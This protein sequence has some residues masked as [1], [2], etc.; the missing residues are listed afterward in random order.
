[1]INVSI[2]QLPPKSLGGQA[3]DVVVEVPGPLSEIQ[4]VA[5]F[6]M[7]KEMLAADSSLGLAGA[8][9][10][11]ERGGNSSLDA[12]GYR[13]LA[14][15]STVRKAAL[16]PQEE[17]KKVGNWAALSKES[18][19]K[20]LLEQLHAPFI[21]YSQLDNLEGTIRCLTRAEKQ[22][23]KS[24]DS[25]KLK[26][27]VYERESLFSTTYSPLEKTVEIALSSG[28]IAKIYRQSL[29]SQI[30]GCFYAINFCLSY[31]MKYLLE[32]ESSFEDKMNKYL[33]QSDS[34]VVLLQIVHNYRIFG[35][36]ILKAVDLLTNI[37]LSHKLYKQP[38]QYSNTENRL[39]VAEM[40]L[41]RYFPEKQGVTDPGSAIFQYITSRLTMP[42]GVLMEGI[43]TDH[44]Q[45]GALKVLKTE[46]EN[47]VLKFNAKVPRK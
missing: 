3:L 21:A 23:G 45:Y 9:G 25:I 29:L 37:Y 17:K 39:K 11:L 34:E 20:F 38:E 41:K 4:R 33:N 24:I 30:K 18:K 1:M 7:Y 2:G 15:V 35:K 16:S 22:L 19:Q 8:T 27:F 47:R 36:E 32:S 12:P 6:N 14:E 26:T 13:V 43:G 28:Q 5:L 42:L 31:G 44:E 46:L 40:K 10:V